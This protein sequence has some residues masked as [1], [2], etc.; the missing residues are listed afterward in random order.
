MVS[1]FRAHK[2]GVRSQGT[3]LMVKRTQISCVQRIKNIG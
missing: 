2:V 3:G 1:G